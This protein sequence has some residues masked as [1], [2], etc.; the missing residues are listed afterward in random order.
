MNRAQ[1]INYAINVMSYA[2]YRLIE[3]QTVTL[4]LR[5]KGLPGMPDI[6][7][8]S[9]SG[10]FIGL[11]F[12]EATEEQITWIENLNATGH[13]RAALVISPKEVVAFM[14]SDNA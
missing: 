8:R 6:I 12:I 2:G 3:T 13:G 1:L 7:G 4:N 14:F 10:R 11:Q 5:A 9:P